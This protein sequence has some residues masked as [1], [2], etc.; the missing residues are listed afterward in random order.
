MNI[1]DAGCGVGGAVFHIAS[2]TKAHVT[3]ISIANNQIVEAKM[4]AKKSPR[5]SNVTFFV[6]D[7]TDSHLPSQSFDCIYGIE[8][9]CY[10]YPKRAFLTEA[11]RLL[12][13]NGTLIIIDGYCKRKPGTTQEKN[14]LDTLCKAY[15]LKELIEIHSMVKEVKKSGFHI[16]S[17]DDFTPLIHKSLE[18]MKL[19]VH[20]GSPFVLLSRI[21]QTPFISS[22]ADNT[23][24][25]SMS[26]EGVH[27]KLF[28]Y[29]A[30]VATKSA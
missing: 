8:S 1:L 17:V 2:H 30:I 20:L 23:L 15:R 24:A 18:R 10:A 12:K 28:G 4:L 25:M 29:Y 3:G 19:L 11:Y 26:I 27:K 22:I 6:G 7:Y 21:I 5:R 9:I 13:P 14:M 16:R